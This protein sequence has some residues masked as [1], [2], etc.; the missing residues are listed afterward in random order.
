MI[1]YTAQSKKF[2]EFWCLIS[3]HLLLLSVELQE[4]MQ[5]F[6]GEGSAECFRGPVFESRAKL[7][8]LAEI[9]F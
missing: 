4:C 6:S 5:D 1:N 3:Q 9:A 7:Y 8:Y 2:W